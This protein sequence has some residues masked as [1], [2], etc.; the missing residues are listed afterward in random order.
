MFVVVGTVERGGEVALQLVVVPLPWRSH[1]DP[2]R[3]TAS[4]KPSASA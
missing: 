3:L 1:L 4:L 2:D